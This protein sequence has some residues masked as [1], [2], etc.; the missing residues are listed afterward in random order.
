MRLCLLSQIHS[1]PHPVLQSEQALSCSLILAMGTWG[2]SNCLSRNRKPKKSPTLKIIH[3][4]AIFDRKRVVVFLNKSK[5]ISTF[6]GG[7]TKMGNY[8]KL[9]PA[10]WNNF[11]FFHKIV[12]PFF[13][14]LYLT[15]LYL[16]SPL[17]REACYSFL[18]SAFVCFV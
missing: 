10:R 17:L 3:F 16:S 12:F 8:P 11:E 4:T 6:W 1:V 18:P 7:L 5:Y 9:N 14:Q 13:Y 15:T 2:S